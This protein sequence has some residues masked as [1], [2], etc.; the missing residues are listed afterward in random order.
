[1]DINTLVKINLKCPICDTETKK[2]VPIKSVG[3]YRAK[4]DLCKHPM[5]ITNVNVSTGYVDDY[6]TP[7]YIND[8][9]ILIDGEQG[10]VRFKYLID[11]DN[12]L[13]DIDQVNHVVR[14]DVYDID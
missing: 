4:C 3:R 1:M 9:V 2:E 5:F 13:H 14:D 10:V 8:D 11:V 7:I 12:G 6:G